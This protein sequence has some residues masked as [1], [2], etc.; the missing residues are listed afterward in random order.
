MEK[1]D[2]FVVIWCDRHCDTTAHVFSRAEDAITWARKQA[3]EYCRNGEPT[4]NLTDTMKRDGWIFNASYSSE[5]DSIHVVQRTID[6]DLEPNAD[7]A[8]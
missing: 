6:N 2:V 3:N 5:G 4:E 1:I 8:Q 7:A